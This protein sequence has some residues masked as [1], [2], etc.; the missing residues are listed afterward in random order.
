MGCGTSRVFDCSPKMETL[1]N[2]MNEFKMPRHASKDVSCRVGKAIFEQLQNEE[3][4]SEFARKYREF[5]PVI[6]LKK[7]SRGR[8][9]LRNQRIQESDPGK[10]FKDEILKL[11]STDGNIINRQREESMKPISEENNDIYRFP[12]TVL[13]NKKRENEKIVSKYH[14]DCQLR[15]TRCRSGSESL[16]PIVNRPRFLSSSSPF[17][18][19]RIIIIIDKPSTPTLSE[20]LSSEDSY[21]TPR[22]ST[23]LI[24]TLLYLE[25][26]SRE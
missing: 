1:A 17:V 8:R 3:R 15:N 6:P 7:I 10:C 13:F 9:Y 26:P 18:N 11:K 19:T 20:E 24:N 16:M 21:T 23:S 22:C 4:D 25:S 5:L 12:N 2:N 14:R